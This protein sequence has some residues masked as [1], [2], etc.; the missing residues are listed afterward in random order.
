MER[1]RVAIGGDSA[2]AHRAPLGRAIR[3]Q[4]RADAER[5]GNDPVDRAVIAE[6][7]SSWMSSLHRGDSRRAAAARARRLGHEQKGTR[8]YG[9]VLQ[10]AICGP[11]S[12]RC[13]RSDVHESAADVVPTG[14]HRARTDNARCSSTN[15]R[16]SIGPELATI[17][18]TS[19]CSELRE[20][21]EALKLA[22]RPVLSQPAEQLVRPQPRRMVVDRR[23]DDHLVRARLRDERLEPRAH[24]LR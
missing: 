2:G 6:I 22:P 1:R 19:P 24:R 21:E 17:G 15:S 9:V 10:S 23:R 4:V 7:R 8:R 12:N 11:R 13:R 5:V 3:E 20:V 16:P 18:R 14:D